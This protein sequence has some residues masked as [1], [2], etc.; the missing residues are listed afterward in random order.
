MRYL[1]FN[2]SWFHS[3][4]FYFLS[5]FI[6][7]ISYLYYF[8]KN[9]SVL[10]YSGLKFTLGNLE[11]RTPLIHFPLVAFTF[12]FKPNLSSNILRW[13]SIELNMY[14][15]NYYS[16]VHIMFSLNIKNVLEI[17]VSNL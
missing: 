12:N 13:K 2:H 1:D 10:Y 4:V 11:I 3:E 9:H 5:L 7:T 8:L 16:E 14:F 6:L 17:G 15:V